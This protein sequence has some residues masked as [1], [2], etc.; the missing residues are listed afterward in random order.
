MIPLAVPNLAGNEARYLQDCIDST[1]VSSVGPFVDR[2]EAQVAAAAGCGGSVATSAGTTGLHAA[3]TAVGVARDDL[4]I[5]PSFT[6]AA[7][8]NAIAH[9]GARPW[10]F[11]I[12]PESWTLDPE[13]LRRSLEAETRRDGNRLIHQPSG[14]R[15]A[16]MMPVYVLG[17]P[18]DMDALVAIAREFGL[19][20]VAD[21]AAALGASYRSRPVGALGA[22][23]SVFSFNGNKTVTCGGGGAVA[24][25]DGELLALVRH[26][27]TTAR[28]GG[29][30]EH[31][32]VGFNYRMTNLQ[33]AVGCAQMERLEDLVTAKRRIS[34]QYDEAFAGLS[35]LEPFPAVPWAESA[36][37]FAGVT[38]G[39]PLPPLER[40]RPLLRDRGI[41]A[42]PFWKP[43]HR[44]APF[45][46]SPRTAMAV[47][48]GLWDRI[49][50]LPCSTGITAGEQEQVIAAVH[51][52]V[53]DLLE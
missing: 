24:G 19:S 27:T 33:A 51:A 38:I 10:L 39:E 22:D 8:A 42:R 4:V 53:R 15:V 11:D 43:M 1:F 21:A 34:R 6:F 20:V 16:A 18:A 32:R 48:D 9:C 28:V 31:D 50:P 41:D 5:L 3:L 52:L 36:C 30:Y 14:R 40:I 49:L 13:L 44:Q 23:L 29:A 45:A 2:F 47:S 26:L 46:D 12:S 37:W 17:L 7:S 35:G 25:D